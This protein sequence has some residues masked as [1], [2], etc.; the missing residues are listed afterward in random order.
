[1]SNINSTDN[2]GG[3]LPLNVNQP[4]YPTN[5]MAPTYWGSHYDWEARERIVNDIANGLINV[6]DMAGMLDIGRSYIGDWG[7][8]FRPDFFGSPR[9]RLAVI[10]GKLKKKNGS[11]YGPE[12][13]ANIAKLVT[14]GRYSIEQVSRQYSVCASTIKRWTEPGHRF[15][16]NKRPKDFV[17]PVVAK[18]STAVI[19]PSK[20]DT[21]RLLAIPDHVRLV[22]NLLLNESPAKAQAVARA[23]LVR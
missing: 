5:G 6:D 2:V 10:K 21:D 9:R 15:H 7:R 20:S 22:I 13:K 1:M 17:P 18:P 3:Q 8:K 11:N 19:A 14:S 12:E 23:L 4:I 16:K